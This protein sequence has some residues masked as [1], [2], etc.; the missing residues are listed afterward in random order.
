M[1]LDKLTDMT[2]R[3]LQMQIAAGADAVQLFDSWAGL[4]DL[5]T[6]EEFGA[7]YNVRIMSALAGA[8]AVRIYF[9]LGAAHLIDAIATIP[10]EMVGVDWRTE[11]GAA[12]ARLP[13]K[14]LQGN[15]DPAYLFSERRTLAAEAE[16][17]IWP[18][19]PLDAVAQL[20]EIV[21][22]YARA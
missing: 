4:H 15:L 21:Q 14:A 17:G 6:F 7:P 13:G 20:V 3:Y 5:R 2:I 16:H 9:A 10:V 8:G 18:E 22:T 12:R 11:L 19:T 1:L